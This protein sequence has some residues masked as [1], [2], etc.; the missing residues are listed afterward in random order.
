M[1]M[2]QKIAFLGLSAMPVDRKVVACFSINDQLVYQ[3]KESVYATARAIN[4]NGA[5]MAALHMLNNAGSLCVEDFPNFTPVE[6]IVSELDFNDAV[7]EKTAAGRAYLNG[8][9]K[10]YH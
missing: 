1:T 8:P 7:R 9:G 2:Q 3:A 4:T 5:Y 10:Q 6:T